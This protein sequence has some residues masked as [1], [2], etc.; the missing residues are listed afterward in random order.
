[1][2]EIVLILFI[3]GEIRVI[4]VPSL[5]FFF[6]M[7]VFITGATGLIGRRLVRALLDRGDTPISLSRKQP[8][9]PVGEVIVGDPTTAGPWVERVVEIPPDRVWARTEIEV[10]PREAG[11]FHSFHYWLYQ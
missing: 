7:H 3:R 6:I 11:M 5:R 10:T 4:R 8:K 2:N 9:E 1:M